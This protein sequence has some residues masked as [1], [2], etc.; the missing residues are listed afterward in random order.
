MLVLG[1]LAFAPAPATRAAIWAVPILDPATARGIVAAGGSVELA[2]HV[3]Y[4]AAAFGRASAHAAR[5][6]FD[7]SLSA[8]ERHLGRQQAFCPL[9]V[10]PLGESVTWVRVRLDH[11]EALERVLASGLLLAP[12]TPP[13]IMI[14]EIWSPVMPPVGDWQPTSFSCAFAAGQPAARWI[15]GD[16]DGDGAREVG[17]YVPALDAFLLD[18]N[19][20]GLWDGVAGGDRLAQVAIAAGPGEP[21]VGDWNGD[22]SDD[23]GKTVGARAF[24]D[25]NGTLRWEGLAGGDVNALFA[26]SVVD[27]GFVAG[28]WTGDGR[29][30]LA[31]YEPALGRFLL[32][33]DGN[34]AWG[35]V[36]GGDGRVD[37]PAL[38]TAAEPFVDDFDGLP[39][40]GVGQAIANSRAMADLDENRRF[41]PQSGDLDYWASRP[42]SGIDFP[43]FGVGPRNLD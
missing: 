5:G 12:L 31:R 26:P 34:G 14:G 32:D 18:A 20:N 35:G 25:A 4:G 2:L 15:Y 6:E 19:G 3:P 24:L 43:G 8:P 29:D 33:L 17:K 23:V 21:L 13:E 42:A 37:F 30:Q 16:W 40:D 22:G 7:W 28:D 1:L 10:A 11:S 36:A 41:E 39:G 38:G 9:D 27:A